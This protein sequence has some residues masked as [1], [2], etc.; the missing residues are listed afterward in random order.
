MTSIQ[1]IACLGMIAGGFLLL[2]IRPIEFT[3]GLFG[4]LAKEPEN[5]RNE[6]HTATKKKKARF[7][8][9]AI[10]EAQQVLKMTGREKQF[11]VICAAALVLFTVGASAAIMIGNFFLA[12]V[13]AVGF[14]FFPFWY[15]ILS[16]SNYYRI[17]ADRRH[18][19]SNRGK[20]SVFESA[21][22]EG[23]PGLYCAD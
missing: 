20:Y 4:F 3:D 22:S 11:S 9:K 6:I 15:V 14:M 18:F 23:I 17:F 2:G 16:A 12:P 1:L 13:M 7:L 5:I 10:I 21:S 8:K 19:D